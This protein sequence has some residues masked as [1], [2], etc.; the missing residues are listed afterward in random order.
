M[1]ESMQTGSF[2]W[3]KS[4][5]KS[6]I[7]N[8]IRLHGPISRA[9]IAKMTTLTPPTVTNIVGE[10]LESGVVL[11]SE[12][13]ESTGGRKPI[14]LTINPSAFQVIGVYVSAHRVLGV[15]CDLNGKTV[16]EAEMSLSPQPTAES[17]LE[18]VQEVI[19]QLEGGIK[20]RETPLLG[21]GVGMHGLVDSDRG[22]SLFAPN[23]SLRNLPL[24]TFLEEHFR[25]PIWVENNVR[26]MVLA[27]SWFGQGKGLDDFICVH[28][29]SGV[30][31]GIFSARSLVRGPSY[32][33]GEL[34]HIIIDSSGPH[35]GCGNTGCLEA[36]ASGPA[37]ERRARERLRAGAQSLLHERFEGRWEKVTG[38]VLT[39]AAREGDPFSKEILAE[40][41]R[42]LG[43]GL[44]NLVNLLNPRRI[45]LNGGVFDAGSLVLEPLENT[46]RERALSA[47]AEDVTIV[48]SDLGK[49]A[50][51]TGSATL[52]LQTLFQPQAE[53]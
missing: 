28:V 53:D 26:A 44:A 49:K 11:E 43:I 3:M 25:V 45:I 6:T 33:A 17:F 42:W 12:L 41:G 15:V 8:V 51:A 40:T 48:V 52:V 16:D 36:F 4:I 21:I 1:A 5:N 38:P 14:L 50:G 22:I 30:G 9:E 13:G 34:G 18:T 19:Q 20:Q 29:G 37:M 10:L 7:L 39:E 27:E 23:L 32:T 24:R 35:C 46:V 31:A 2:R 47:P